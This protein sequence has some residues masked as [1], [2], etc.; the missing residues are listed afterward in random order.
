MVDVFGA[1]HAGHV[2]R[3]K[4]GM[5]AARDRRSEEAQFVLVQI[6]RIV[7]GG[8]EVKVS[9]RKGTVF[10][11]GDLIEE[12]GPTCAGSAFLMKTP[13]T[14]SSTSISTR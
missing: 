8:E 9:K 12:A 10:E 11:L 5:R 13:R 7:R 2:P 14:R 4:A 1:D 3:I 6:V